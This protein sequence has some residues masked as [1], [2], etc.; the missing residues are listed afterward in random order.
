M[1]QPMMRT[2]LE[3]ILREAVE[4]IQW[5]QDTAARHP[6]W[7]WPAPLLIFAK[8]FQGLASGAPLAQDC[9]RDFKGRL[10]RHI[11]EGRLKGMEPFIW[12][13]EALEALATGGSS[14]YGASNW[15]A[16]AASS[17]TSVGNEKAIVPSLAL[18]TLACP[19]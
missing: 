18:A 12:R 9:I 5:L 10:E 14:G 11:R 7:K 17:R 13:V 16:L 4:E 8:E 15:F 19:P 2:P 3:V 6:S 1:S